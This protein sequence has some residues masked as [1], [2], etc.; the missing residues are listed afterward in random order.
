[1]EG[2]VAVETAVDVVHEVFHGYRRF[3]AVQ[4]KLNITGRRGQ[5]NV[6]VGLR[7]EGSGRD[8]R[9][10]KYSRHGSQSRFEHVN[11][12]KRERESLRIA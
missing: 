1:M 6:R 10:C 8:G 2:G 12:F 3:L 7:R 4:L 11:S 5:Q 9:K